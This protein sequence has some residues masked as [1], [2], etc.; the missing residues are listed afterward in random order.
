MGNRSLDRGPR[1]LGEDILVR[2]KGPA[3]VEPYF[4]PGLASLYLRG[5]E[6]NIEHLG[7]G[8]ADYLKPMGKWVPVMKLPVRIG[9]EITSVIQTPR[10]LIVCGQKD[11]QYHLYGFKYV[12]NGA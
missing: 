10:M 3:P 4:L 1:T 6:T 12:G 5:E 2:A 9:S 11:D 7:G 8:L